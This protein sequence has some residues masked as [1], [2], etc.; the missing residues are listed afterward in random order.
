MSFICSQ[1]PCSVCSNDCF[2][3]ANNTSAPLTNGEANDD[4]NES[5]N[6]ENKNINRSNSKSLTG[7]GRDT[8]RKGRD[9]D[10]KSD[11]DAGKDNLSLR[12]YSS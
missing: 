4:F 8:S 5:V 11:K 10:K 2:R 3:S 1:S 7:V 9:G 12:I 6:A